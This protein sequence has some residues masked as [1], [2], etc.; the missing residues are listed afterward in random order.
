[1]IFQ[2]GVRVI[3]HDPLE[4]VDAL[5]SDSNFDSNDVLADRS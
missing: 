5:L 3:A 4:L 2:S 1:M